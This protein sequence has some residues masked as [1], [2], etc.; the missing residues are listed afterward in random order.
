LRNP[1]LRVAAGAGVATHLPL[2]LYLLGLNAIAKGAPPLV[3]KLLAVLVF[4]VIW[5]A[6]PFWALFV[7]IRR[8]EAARAAIGRISAWML[9]HERAALILVLSTIGAYFTTRG[10]LD[11]LG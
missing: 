10:V 11:L 5:M 7:S 8:P 6:I 3:E 4:D 9:K 2:P 1:S